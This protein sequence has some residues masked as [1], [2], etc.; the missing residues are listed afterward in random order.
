MANINKD[1]LVIVDVKKSSI[2][3][4]NGSMTFNILDK[5]TSNIFV[6]LVIN[7]S[8][9]ELIHR[10]TNIENAEDYTVVMNIVKPNNEYLTLEGELRDKEKAVFEFN[11]P[12]E[13]KDVIGTYNCELLTKCNING[14]EEV[15]TSNKVS[16]RVKES[17]L[18]NLDD[19]ITE[20]P[21]YPIVIELFDRL[22]D[23]ERY[24]EDR[25]QAEIAR[26]LAET[27]RVEAEAVREQEHDVAM[28]DIEDKIVEVEGRFIEL[29]AEVDRQFQERDK[30]IV[31]RFTQH[32]NVVAGRL[33]DQD[34]AIGTFINDST[35]RMDT[36]E[37][38]VS[39]QIAEVQA[40]D[41]EQDE[42]M[43]AIE[44][45]N[46]IQNERLDKVEKKNKEQDYTLACLFAETDRAEINFD[47][48][49]EQL[50]NS[51]DGLAIVNS[52]EGQTMVNLNKEADKSLTLNGN[53]DKTGQSVDVT[54]GADG[55]LVDVYLEGNTMV[56]VCDQQDSVPLTMSYTSTEGNHVALQGDYDGKA[57][58]YIYG[59]T[60]VNLVPKY[61]ID[62]TADGTWKS[63]LLVSPTSTL[64]SSNPR[65][66]FDVK[67]NTTYTV[68]LNVVENTLN[69][70][71]HIN[72]YDS[73][74][75]LWREMAFVYVGEV[76]IKTF[77][78]TTPSDITGLDIILR[79]QLS[80]SAT[81][82][83]ILIKDIIVLEG[84]YTNK[85][86]PTYFE[87]LQSSFEE[88]VIPNTT[89]KSYEAN[90][91]NTTN[92][93]VL[94]NNTFKIQ[95]GT[96]VN[97]SSI[98]PKP[99]VHQYKPNTTYTVVVDILE[100]TCGKALSVSSSSAPMP[101]FT[102]GNRNFKNLTGVSAITF[103][104]FADITH[105]S[106]GV[107]FSSD[108]YFGIWDANGNDDLSKYIT[109]KYYIFEGDYSNHDFSDY[110]PSK[111]GKYKVEYVSIG[112]NKATIN[113]ITCDGKNTDFNAGKNV[114]AKNIEP[115]AVISWKAE[116]SSMGADVEALIGALYEDGTKEYV[117][118][119]YNSLVL[120]D[121]KRVKEIVLLNY[122]H[123]VGTVYDI[124]VEY[125]TQTAYEPYKEYTKT[126]YLN[127]PLL[128]GD[129]IEVSGNNI[130]HVHRRDRQ[131]LD[132]SEDNFNKSGEWQYRGQDNNTVWFELLSDKLNKNAEWVNKPVYCDR[133]TYRFN[134]IDTGYED[135]EGIQTNGAIRIRINKSRLSS[136]DV[137]G[138]K[139][140][141][142]NNLTT[143]EYALRTPTYEVISTNDN[144]Y[145]DSY[146]N[147]H[148]DFDSAVP[149]EKVKFEYFTTSLKYLKP[150]TEYVV[151][152][153]ADNAGHAR[154][155]NLGGTTLP[156][157]EVKK[158]LNKFIISTESSLNHN[159]L[160]INGIGC[161]ISNIV[162]T[163]AVNED[164]G[165]FQGMKSVGECEELEIISSNTDNTQ[166]NSKQLTHEPLRSTGDVKDRYVLIDGEW[167]IERNCDERTYEDG[168]ELNLPTDKVNTVYPLSASTYEKIDYNPF[169]VYKDMTHITTN[170]TIPAN[171]KVKN[172]GFNA[173]LKPSTTYT[174]SSNQGVQIFQTGAE[175]DDSLRLYGTGT[176][177][178]VTILE[179]AITDTG[180]IPSH[181]DGMQSSFEDKL[182]DDGT[183]R[184]EILS[185]NKNLYTFGDLINWGYDN[186]SNESILECIKVKPNTTYTLSKK[187]EGLLHAIEYTSNNIDFKNGLQ[188]NGQSFNHNSVYSNRSGNEYKIFN[189]T[190][191]IV[192]TTGENINYLWITGSNGANGS[193]NPPVNQTNI[194]LEENNN[195]TSYV[196]H[197]SNKIQFSSIEPL[198]G[199]GDVRDDVK[200]QDGKVIV[201][202]RCG[203]VILDGSE[204]W[205]SMGVYDTAR[206]F[207][208]GVI[209]YLMAKG[210]VT[211]N[212]I[213]ILSDRFKSSKNTTNGNV[214]LRNNNP[215]IIISVNDGKLSTLDI[216]GFKK[217]LSEN[218]VKVVYQL[219]E[220]T[221][222]EIELD[223][224]KLF[225]ESYKDGHIS[226]N[227]NIS[228][229]DTWVEYSVAVA[230]LDNLLET[231]S[232]TDEQDFL[233]V[234]LATQL[235]IMQLTM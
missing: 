108:L 56:N 166:F 206:S 48:N 47:G 219:A 131:L 81:T 12:A 178:D 165:Y 104:T 66:L 145:I 160:V 217:W 183:Y 115:G 162:V 159:L 233:I 152:F 228:V 65:A 201:T 8:T 229:M 16:Y 116:Y 208:S 140:W 226:F 75:S 14:Q 61:E 22:S 203:E 126:L 139:Q 37:Q 111:A 155:I 58:P 94:G 1:Y 227:S 112:K 6:N 57:K 42:R 106:Q 135:A 231:A 64:S 190:G 62:F 215:D 172:H 204:N 187:G 52:F 114:I 26:E 154:A 54:E 78:F 11:L 176:M 216:A 125:G 186:G 136:I 209:R 133:F 82:G 130:V 29:E 232:I 110:D 223:K 199:I 71:C 80:N 185:N 34:E 192:F 218:P 77:I 86:I 7:T 99:G 89:V 225:L 161:N 23:I 25:R 35:A 102:A 45:I 224:E 149:V 19:V 184:M 76:G 163:E 67:P 181:F 212:Y 55:G 53:I 105:S 170:S 118:P 20:A 221:V 15:T 157:Q 117:R 84:D 93:Q 167:Y 150:L 180:L 205:Y 59:N 18:N 9:N 10:F 95:C 103:T 156:F 43:T 33:D 73:A 128:K 189:D 44:V 230:M 196:P 38:T 195:N 134:L 143:V 146:A 107:A 21:T 191:K 213:D 50:L 169:S 164:F 92:A 31:A 90:N 4:G 127:S 147:G 210:P 2:S 200:V 68:L 88:Q 36:H 74:R 28:Q 222:E 188:A 174:I 79:T 49:S 235:A 113:Q 72:N 234:D 60:M 148:L 24:E 171:L 120:S 179:G 129:S 168:D 69:Y 158:G 177:K 3:L 193:N 202:R 119:I 17:V 51:K 96:S 153:E 207:G 97:S 46:N 214:I 142:A 5:N 197:K 182:Q 122:C 121:T 40:K 63:K 123:M 87:G 70:A 39:A 175:L 41:R 144:L 101:N 13:A 138:F 83:R 220:P 124:Q 109:F 132:G 211:G 85:P 32:E 198:R 194:Q 141:L 27:A 91:F 151:Q 173:M 100:N 30:T 137:D 98:R